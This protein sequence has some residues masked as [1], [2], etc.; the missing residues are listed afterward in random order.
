MQIL[1]TTDTVG[2]VWQYSLTLAA[3]LRQRGLGVALAVVGPP[4]SATQFAAAL[5]V[6]RLTCHVYP[7]RLEWQPGCAADLA[8]SAAWL[9]DLAR[10]LGV[11][12]IHSNQ[13]AY[14]ALR[15]GVPVI[16]VAHSD[17][18]SWHAACDPLTSAT[19]PT[20]RDHLTAYER[21]VAAG[22]VGAAAVV[23]PSHAL[24]ADLAAHYPGGGRATV[25]YN[26]VATADDL[27]PQPPLLKG[28]GELDRI[29]FPP[30]GQG[31]SLRITP[32]P[33]GEGSG[34]G[35]SALRVL[36]VG[37]LWDRAKGLDWLVEA[38]GDGL[39][40]LEVAVAG[41][42]A[43]PDGSSEATLPPGIRALGPLGHADLLAALGQADLY[44]GLSRYEPFGLAPLEAATQGCAL[45]LRDIPT[46]R[47]L[48]GDTATYCRSAAE[49]RAA[50]LAATAAPTLPRCATA[51]AARYS[52]ARM[53]SAYLR[54]YGAVGS[55]QWAG[56]RG[57]SFAIVSSISEGMLTAP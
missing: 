57:Q 31:E 12:L 6:P 15:V 32:P 46:F 54:L 14:G 21:V 11:D 52:V 37:R 25:I 47:E 18:L 53:T 16:V 19:D 30:E 28:E 7:G 20:W 29:S 24:A 23:C 51:H 45:L 1:L 9:G 49:V 33:L 42:L 38:V 43:G 22:L 35:S 8:E 13:F 10:R 50:L 41:D 5:A 4:P 36:S 34:E 2:G 27:S 40:G 56:G 39:P 44:V 26:G 3:A 48:W 17:L 55:G